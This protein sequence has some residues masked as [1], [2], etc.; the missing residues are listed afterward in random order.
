MSEALAAAFAGST[1]RHPLMDGPT[2]TDERPR[3]EYGEYATPEQQAAAMG[4]RYVPPEPVSAPPAPPA[5]AP[6]VGRPSGYANRFFTI[7]LLGL[8]ALSLFEN[9]PTFLN[10]ATAL[11]TAATTAGMASTTVPSS[12]NGAGIPILV[13]NVVIYLAAVL[14]SILALRRGR[15]SFYIPVVGFAVFILVASILIVAY[16]PRYFAQFT[17]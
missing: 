1:G 11:K 2:M 12:V 5:P 10:L 17:S 14:L 13:A 6:Y 16:A 15:T 4:H 9:V 8:G 7:F 3:P